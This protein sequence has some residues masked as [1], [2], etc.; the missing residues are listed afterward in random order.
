MIILKELTWSNAFSYGQNNRIRLD[1]EPLVQLVGKNGAGKTSIPLLLQEVLYGKNVKSIKKQDISNRHTGING[2]DIMVSFSNGTDDF[3]VTLN[4]KT[5]IKLQLLKNGEDISSHTSVNTYKQISDIIGIE[6]FKIF[7]QLIYQSSTGSLE[8]LTATDT[9]RK[10]FLI[11]LLQLEKYLELFD[12]FK[13]KAKQKNLELATVEGQLESYKKW[14]DKHQNFSFEV[15]KLPEAIDDRTAKLQAEL[16]TLRFEQTN[17]K[18]LNR[19]I[20]DNNTNKK[21]LAALD[22]GLMLQGVAQFDDQKYST[23]LKI[24]SKYKSEKI[25]PTNL[26]KK[27]S[28]LTNKCPTC[29]QDISEEYVEKLKS[30]A[31]STINTCELKMQEAKIIIDEM[32]ELKSAI[33]KKEK[34]AARFEELSRIIDKSIKSDTIDSVELEEKIVAKQAEISAHKSQLKLIADLTDSVKTHNSKIEIV[35]EQ[36]QQF[37]NE[38]LQ[39]NDSYNKLQVEVNNLEVLKKVFSTNG[40]VSYKIESSVKELEKSINHYLREFSHFQIF[41]KL[42]KDKLNIRVMD[43]TGQETAIES[44]SAGELGRVNIS[45]V[46]AIRNIMSSLSSTKIN[47]LFLDEIVGVLDMEGKER[48]TELL[49]LENLNTFMVSHEYEHPLVPKYNIV[50]ENNI[51]RIENGD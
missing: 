22:L 11:T 24:F 10:K 2:Y 23:N 9:N 33:S 50:K 41:F 4:R 49:L 47:F 13:E 39:L 5:N 38:M 7:T 17:I 27:M 19:K 42:D 28:A 44:L 18:Q 6:D 15:K 40:L 12:V 3:V 25:E 31:N 8:F 32:E 48:L 35:K 29:F 16:D 30:E 46:L 37:Q 14:I 20:I 51:S 1:E 36:L 26:L 45:T 21:E 43:D 34:I